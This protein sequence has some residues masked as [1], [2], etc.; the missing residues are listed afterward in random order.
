MSDYVRRYFFPDRVY[1]G[2][3]VKWRPIKG[4]EK[5][6][7]GNLKDICM[8][9]SAEDYLRLPKRFDNF[10]EADLP[11][12]ARAKY[13]KFEKELSISLDGREISA[14]NPAVLTGKLLQMVNGAIYDEDKA[15]RHIHDAK[16]EALDEIIEASNGKHILVY[17]YF[18][19]DLERLIEHLKGTN[20][21]VLDTS[22]DVEGWNKVEIAVMLAHPKSAGHGLD[23]QHGG[24]IIVWFGLTWSL[25][26][27]Q[28]ANARL[29]RQ[30]QANYVTVNHIIA[31]GTIDEDVM[32][33][34]QK[35]GACQEDILYAVKE[36]LKKNNS[37]R[38]KDT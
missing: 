1:K 4:A 23:L 7:T 27:Y 12:S 38:E 31:K 30:G 21:R 11:A 8:S 26:E 35:K 15:V 3:V 13:L 36:R 28:K 33:V 14:A 37:W 6:I 24:D 34:L 9:M 22:K 16:L 10:I 25:E 32:W 19:H 29:H 18:K 17:Y 5:I 2:R 20:F